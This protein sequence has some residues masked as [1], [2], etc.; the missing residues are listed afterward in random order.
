MAKKK[1]KKKTSKKVSK[2]KKVV[3]V[4]DPK[5]KDSGNQVAKNIIATEKEALRA[6]E[7]DDK[8]HWK[9]FIIAVLIVFAVAFLGS[10]VTTRVVES[11]WYDNIKP[12]ITPPDYVFPIVWNILFFLLAASMYLAW[13]HSKN[14]KRKIV[15][16]EYGINLLLNFSWSFVFFGL[17]QPLFAFIVL[18]ALWVSIAGLIY[19]TWSINK[20]SSYFLIPYLLWVSFAG[21]LNFLMII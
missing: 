20:K 17:K 13:I 21:V 18:L 19:T 5:I 7:L 1:V 12:S 4:K 15:A 16:L 8:H 3:R 9:P 11:E 6:L 2:K 10:S 14:K